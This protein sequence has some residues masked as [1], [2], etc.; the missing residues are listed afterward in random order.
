MFMFAQRK[1]NG[2]VGVALVAML[3]IGLA[4]CSGDDGTAGP[5]GPA[6]PTGPAGPVG[7]PGTPAPGPGVPSIGSADFI[8]PTITGV[9][10]ASPATVSFRL[11]DRDGTLYRGVSPSNVRF[12]IARLMP[13]TGGASSYWVP[14]IVSSSSG[15]PTYER[16]NATGGVFTDNGDGTYTYRFSFDIATRAGWDATRTHRVGMQVDGVGADGNQS[17]NAVYTW[18]PST[19]ATT[20]IFSREIV[21]TDTCNSCHDRLRIHGRRTDIGYCVTCHN[22]SNVEADFKVFIHKIHAGEHLPSV[23]AGGS[24]IVGGHDYS[25]VEWPQDIRNCQTCHDES[26]AKTPQAQNWRMVQN[27]ASCGSCHDDVNFTTGAGHAAGAVTD[28]QCTLCHGPNATLYQSRLRVTTVHELKNITL[29]AQFRFEV[30]SVDGYADA[31]G[32]VPGAAAG[33][34]APGEYAKVKIK[35]SNPQTGQAYDILTGL[36][37]DPANPFT[38]KTVASGQCFGTTSTNCSASLNVLLAWSNDDFSNLGSSGSTTRPAYPH[39]VN[40]LTGNGTGVTNNGDGTFSKMA[41]VPV[42]A[43]SISGSGTAF[44]AGRPVVAIGHVDNLDDAS[45]T[46]YARGVVDAG[47]RVFRIT[48]ATAV[49]RR[50]VNHTTG[51]GGVV[52]IDNCNDCHKKVGGIVHGGSYGAN[53]TAGFV[54]AACHTPDTVCD[55]GEATEDGMDHK[56]WI[57]LLHAGGFSDANCGHGDFGG[58]VYPGHLNNCEGCHRPNT[59]YPVDATKVHATS[60]RANAQFD[61]PADDYNISPNKAVCASCHNEPLYLEHMRLNGASFDEANGTGA[62]VQTVNGVTTSGGLE[63]CVLCHGPGKTADIR[64]MHNIDSYKYN[65]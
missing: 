50:N 62:V 2:M 24:Y 4:G 5:A 18:Q 30:V 10:V 57:H 22:P 13:G 19:G 41:T 32:A 37:T 28:D 29:G 58:I 45:P 60:I 23:Q 3:A 11:A 40:F 9:S 1:S 26:D 16:G 25:H 21:D 6:G 53:N 31:A 34:V 48:D 56:R 61:S 59:F 42:P 15:N 55:R 36:G 7:P 63:T 51:T 27:A 39:Q 17:E 54:C 8:V 52:N 47:A 35:V 46:L 65:R 12:T 20:N 38:S 33:R 64:V 43:S 44:L 14:Y 49:T